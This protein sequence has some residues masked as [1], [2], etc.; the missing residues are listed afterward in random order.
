MIRKVFGQKIWRNYREASSPSVFILSHNHWGVN[1][2]LPSAVRA[3]SSGTTATTFSD[4]PGVKTSGEKY[5]IMYTC[6][7]CNTRSAR[8]ISKKSYHEG[9]VVVLCSHCKSMHLIAD[10]VGLFENKGWDIQKYLSSQGQEKEFKHVNSD[11]VFELSA[12]EVAG[13]TAHLAPPEVKN[14]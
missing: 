7:V 1:Y 3:F 2:C 14:E 4:V 12:E 13:I 5:V 10:H 6:K 8:Q 9:V 11:N